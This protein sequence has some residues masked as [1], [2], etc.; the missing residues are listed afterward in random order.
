ME[1]RFDI[2]RE[3]GT[4]TGATRARSEVHREGLWHRAFHLFLVGCWEGDSWTILQLRAPGKDVSP[5]RLD[6]AV[7]G[8]FSAG[9]ALPGVVRETEEEIGLRVRPEELTFLWRK[10]AVHVAPGIFDR[11]WQEVYLLRRDEPV[12]AYRPDP[13]ELAGLFAMR[14]RDLESLLAGTLGDAPASGLLLENGA[15]V[16]ATRR[17]TRAD[18]IAGDEDNLLHLARAA[19]AWLAAQA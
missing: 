2:L 15:W 14:L 9:E 13:V 4:P 16:P 19:M 17:F 8:H 3:D 12:G 1:E 10:Q 5:S 6:V 11:E 7:G 18:F